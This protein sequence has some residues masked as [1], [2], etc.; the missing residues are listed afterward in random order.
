[1]FRSILIFYLSGFV[2]FFIDREYRSLLFLGLRLIIRN[3]NSSIKIQKKSFLFNDRLGLFWQY[4]E[5]YYREYYH[6]KPSK[7]E[8]GII[9]DCGANI[10]LSSLYFCQNYPNHTVIAFEPDPNVY[11]KLRTNLG[12]YE[13]KITLINSAVYTEEGIQKFVSDGKDGGQL[14]FHK[15]VESR[16]IEV[17]TVHFLNF[18]SQYESIDMLKIDIEGAEKELI[19]HIAPALQKVSNLFIEYHQY[20]DEG[21]FLS[22]LLSIL[23]QNGFHYKLEVPVKLKAPLISTKVVNQ[24]FLQVNIFA[25]KQ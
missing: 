25:S 19:P 7:R 11:Q 17:K 4:Y 8:E 16:I 3:E 12:H 9:V 15:E 14:S 23:E 18:L 5:I 21:P 22:H 13:N 6:F 2:K 10:G 1:M 20:K 24:C